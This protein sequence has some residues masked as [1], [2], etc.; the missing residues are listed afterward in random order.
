M[1]KNL[2]Q[3][4]SQILPV[5]LKK[6]GKPYASESLATFE[7]FDAM[8]RHVEKVVRRTA[9]EILGGNC[10]VSPVQYRGTSPCTYCDYQDMCHFDQKC[11]S[12]YRSLPSAKAADVWKKIM[13]EEK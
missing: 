1:D 12:R 5:K 8:K 2:S 4:D 7:E 6:D 9:K 10:A 3:G 11:G 13:E